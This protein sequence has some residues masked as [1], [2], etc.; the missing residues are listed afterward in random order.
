M[1]FPLRRLP[2]VVLSILFNCLTPEELI[3]LSFLSKRFY[4]LTKALKKKPKNELEIYFSSFASIGFDYQFVV[5]PQFVVSD[6]SEIRE[7]DKLEFLVIG[8]ALPCFVSMNQHTLGM[9]I[10][11]KDDR[12]EGLTVLSKYI[13]N[14]YGIQ[15]DSVIIGAEKSIDDP[16]RII[17]WVMNRQGSVRSC[18]FECRISGNSEL[19]Y[20][21]NNCKVSKSLVIDVQTNRRFRYNFSYEH[22]VMTIE[23][24]YELRRNDG[25]IASIVIDNGENENF[26]M[27]VWPDFNGKLYPVQK[28]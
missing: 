28:L 11:C 1:S 20:L 2:F 6:L 14:F 27:C 8:D 13:T 5:E 7:N 12:F 3:R 19:R 17:D 18:H 9:N 24:S 16:K 21:F 15:I 4:A 23:K 22:G 26:C 25:T 10:Y